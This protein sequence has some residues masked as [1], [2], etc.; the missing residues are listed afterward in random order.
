MGQWSRC[1]ATC[2]KGIQIRTVSCVRTKSGELIDRKF[3]DKISPLSERECLNNSA[4]LHQVP[5]TS[6]VE[7]DHENQVNFH[8][9]KGEWSEVRNSKF[10]INT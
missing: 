3:C 2:G 7:H 10:F 6:H 8:W 5:R 1:S 9:R 4:C